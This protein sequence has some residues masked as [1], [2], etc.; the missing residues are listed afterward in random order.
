MSAITSLRGAIEGVTDEAED[1]AVGVLR[2]IEGAALAFV[3]AVFVAVEVSVRQVVQ[4]GFG[5]ANT[6]VTEGFTVLDS[7]VTAALGAVEGDEDDDEDEDAAIDPADEE[8]DAVTEEV[9]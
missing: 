8:E 4:V 6:F 9:D 5:L 7:V 1:R 2:A 3:S